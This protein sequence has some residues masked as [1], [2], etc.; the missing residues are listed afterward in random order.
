MSSRFRL[1]ALIFASIAAPAVGFAQPAPSAEVRMNE[2]GSENA[3]LA[4]RIGTYDVV[5]T[6]WSAP[7]AEPT[8]IRAVAER[9]TVGSILQEV[10][11]FPPGPPGSDFRRIDY[12]SF[13]RVEGRWKYVSMDAR[14]PVG[15]MWATSFGRG[16]DGR[17]TV[18]FE[19][20]ALAGP[21]AGVTGQMVSMDQAVIELDADHDAKEQRFMLADGTGV[22]W[23]ANRYAYTRRR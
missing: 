17:F 1:C 4:Q 10:I 14:F 7:G 19:P 6:S 2:L 9:T 5:L 3:R 8:T 16:Q 23:L 15:I 18:V 21:G 22:M 11:T 20:F 13:N 12:L